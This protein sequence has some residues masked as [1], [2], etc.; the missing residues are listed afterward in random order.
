M[1]IMQG[2]KE[3]AGQHECL[4]DKHKAVKLLVVL[5]ATDTPPPPDNMFILDPN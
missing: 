3:T 2:M 4:A 5:G 1:R